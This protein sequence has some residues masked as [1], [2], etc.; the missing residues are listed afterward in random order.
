VVTKF[1]DKISLSMRSAAA[2]GPSSKYRKWPYVRNLKTL[3]TYSL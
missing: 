1:N 2:G 3:I